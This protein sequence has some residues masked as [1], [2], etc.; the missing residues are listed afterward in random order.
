MMVNVKGPLTGQRIELLDFQLWILANLFGFV[1][2]AS[3][4]RRFWQASI[5]V[6]RGNGKSVLAAILA[7]AVT[8]FE[9]EG[10]R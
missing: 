5:W 6:P 2:R 9:D 8:F 3:G 10:G 4:L 7:L 1:E